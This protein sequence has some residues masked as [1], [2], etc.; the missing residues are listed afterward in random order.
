VVCVN[1]DSHYGRSQSDQGE[2]TSAIG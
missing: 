2:I 1:T